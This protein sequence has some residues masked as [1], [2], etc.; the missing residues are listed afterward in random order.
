MNEMKPCPFCNSYG[1]I[2]PEE[3]ELKSTEYSHKWHWVEC[4]VCL[5][6][7]PECRT[8]EDAKKEWNTRPVED[9]LKAEL[10]QALAALR[11]V[12]W[13]YEYSFVCPWCDAE[14]YYRLPNDGHYP[15]CPRQKA[16]G[17]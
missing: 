3:P 7:G 6:R 1:Q 10:E 14:E 13:V 17:L 12:E 9:K 5:A 11:M 2:E 8:P 4:P 16:L 15:D